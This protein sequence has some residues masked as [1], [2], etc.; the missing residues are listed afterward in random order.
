MRRHLSSLTPEELVLME[1][2]AEACWFPSWKLVA[3]LL[4]DAAY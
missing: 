2:V 4:D 1:Q 3:Y